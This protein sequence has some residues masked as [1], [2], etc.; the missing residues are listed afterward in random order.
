MSEMERGYFGG[1]FDA[2]GH[3]YINNVGLVVVEVQNTNIDVLKKFQER[4]GGT[5]KPHRYKSIGLIK[6]YA[7]NAKP[8]WRYRLF[9]Q[10]DVL[11]FFTDTIDCLV[12]KKDKGLKFIEYLSREIKTGVKRFKSVVCQ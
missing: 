1:F 7:D 6:K 3:A 2:D 8:K 5:I 10:N 12:V 4:Y 9:R 11:I